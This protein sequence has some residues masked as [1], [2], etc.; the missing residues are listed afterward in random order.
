MGT[1]IGVPFR[2]TQDSMLTPILLPLE[3]LRFFICVGFWLWR[4]GKNHSVAYIAYYY[5]DTEIMILIIIKKLFFLTLTLLF[6]RFY[7]RHQELRKYRTIKS[8][9][10]VYPAY[11]IMWP[12]VPNCWK[13]KSV[14][15]SIVPHLF[16]Q[17]LSTSRTT[18]AVVRSVHVYGNFAVWYSRNCTSC[19]DRGNN[20][21]TLIKAFSDQKEKIHIVA[22]HWAQIKNNSLVSTSLAINA[23]RIAGRLRSLP[24]L[25]VN[26]RRS[27][28]IHGVVR[29]FSTRSDEQEWHFSC[30][31]MSFAI[32]SVHRKNK[33][34]RAGR[35]SL[36]DYTLIVLKILK[37]LSAVLIITPG[38]CRCQWTSFTSFWPWNKTRKKWATF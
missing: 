22:D 7:A 29:N 34:F 33:T 36:L 2:F 38:N 10:P 17:S 32:F 19:S 16:N 20:N 14:C 4:S 11:L 21:C 1:Y 24:L 37:P 8:S 15:I 27:F 25:E 35:S 6:E 18:N 26:R 13:V 12:S 31:F 23:C 5:Q 3:N 9:P 28:S 30:S